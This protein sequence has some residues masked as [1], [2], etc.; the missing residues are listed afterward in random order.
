MDDRLRNAGS[1]IIDPRKLRDYALN[2]QHATGRY[3]AAFFAQMGYVSEH[4]QDLEKDIREQHLILPAKPG[5]VSPFG[6]KYT[7]TGPLIG[8]AGITR[9]ITTVWIIRSGKD[10][11]ELVT[12]EPAAIRKASQDE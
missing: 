3:K 2:F 10:N 9:Q 7:V 4:W 8:P 11:P 6:V 5:K 1:A 12:I